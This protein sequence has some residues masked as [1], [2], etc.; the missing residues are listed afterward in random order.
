[1]RRWAAIYNT[2]E[3]GMAFLLYLVVSYVLPAA[4]VLAASATWWRTMSSPW[5]YLA[6]MALS[7]I[8][9]RAA[10][11]GLWAF[12]RLSAGSGGFV[13]EQRP[14]GWEGALMFQS[15]GQALIVLAV[16]VPLLIAVKNVF[17]KL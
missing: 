4:L 3:L 1:M 13:L 10:V 7:M 16:G 15:I 17:A 2:L 5:L 8:G 14:D 6:T 9:L 11:A 12:V